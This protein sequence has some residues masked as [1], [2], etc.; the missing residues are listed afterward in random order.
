MPSIM[1]THLTEA[2]E[3]NKNITQAQI[4]D[5]DKMY[6]KPLLPMLL[7]L[8]IESNDLILNNLILTLIFKCFSQRFLNF[9][10]FFLNFKM[11]NKRIIFF[12]Y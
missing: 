4:E 12:L 3:T 9:F 7:N 8:F 5:L 6:G 11:R 10:I 2:N 1:Q